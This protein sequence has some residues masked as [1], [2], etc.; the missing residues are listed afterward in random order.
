MLAGVIPDRLYVVS[1][2]PT[3]CGQ[4]ETHEAG[5]SMGGCELCIFSKPSPP[6]FFQK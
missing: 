1:F 3:L 6:S 2:Q 4:F 5:V